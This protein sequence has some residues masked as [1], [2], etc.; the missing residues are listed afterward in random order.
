MAEWKKWNHKWITEEIN[1]VHE[2]FLVCYLDWI[3]VY[4]SIQIVEEKRKTQKNSVPVRRKLNNCDQ[5][6]Q[7]RKTRYFIFVGE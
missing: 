1:C 3:F 4:D 7:E 2:K 5:I 6:N